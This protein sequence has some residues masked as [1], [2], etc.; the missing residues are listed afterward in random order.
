MHLFVIIT[1][2]AAAALALVTVAGI[3]V[4]MLTFPIETASSDAQPPKLVRW[5]DRNNP[6]EQ[7]PAE[8]PACGGGVPLRPGSESRSWRTRRSITPRRR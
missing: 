2:Y 3:G 8:A 1:C 5:A 4:S 6:G 7:Q